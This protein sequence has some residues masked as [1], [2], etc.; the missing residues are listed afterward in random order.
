MAN[1]N[2]ENRISLT[3]KSESLAQIV[4]ELSASYEK[5]ESFTSMNLLPQIRTSEIG[6]LF[7]AVGVLAF[8]VAVA[9]LVTIG[10]NINIVYDEASF[11]GYGYPYA[12]SDYANYINIV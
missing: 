10:F 2:F 5:R 6:G 3:R 8:A 9:A 1:L 4:E 7:A 12:M 11:W